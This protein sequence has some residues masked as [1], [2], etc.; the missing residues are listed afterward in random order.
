MPQAAPPGDAAIEAM[1][2]AAPSG[3]A[4]PEAMP[5]A[6]PP[7]DAAPEAMPVALETPDGG[8]ELPREPATQGEPEPVS[9]ETDTAKA[10]SADGREL[11][12]MDLEALLDATGMEVNPWEKIIP[13][14]PRRYRIP[15]PDFLSSL[16][17]PVAEDEA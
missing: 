11:P 12:L 14:L 17:G 16:A 3:N 15:D 13:A 8:L 1:P 2:Q 9:A 6:A 10:V 5:Q 7:G 4:A